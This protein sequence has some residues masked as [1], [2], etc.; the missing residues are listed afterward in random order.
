MLNI[1]YTESESHS[2]SGHFEKPERVSVTVESLITN[3]KYIKY[4]NFGDIYDREIVNNLIVK[5]HGE[6]IM[7]SFDRTDKNIICL[8]C[9]EIY[10][11]SIS[12]PK[13]ESEDCTWYSDNDTYITNKSLINIYVC[14]NKLLSSLDNIVKGSKYQYLLIRYHLKNI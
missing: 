2:N 11:N 13:C 9:H 3:Q 5:S 7:R 4:F 6:G 8:E 10:K 12:C 1:L 14:I